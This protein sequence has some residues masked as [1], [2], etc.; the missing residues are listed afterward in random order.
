MAERLKDN[1]VFLCF[2]KTVDER[3]IKNNDTKIEGRISIYG[4]KRFCRNIV[5]VF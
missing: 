3:I 5:E 1:Y 4:K 2:R